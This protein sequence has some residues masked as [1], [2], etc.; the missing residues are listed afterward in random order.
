MTGA[1]FAGT[2]GSVN[3]RLDG[4]QWNIATTGQ[5][6]LGILLSTNGTLT[7]TAGA[8]SMRIKYIVT[9]IA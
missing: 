3:S 4:G 5:L 6:S 8:F 9:K 7:T 2:G 1:F